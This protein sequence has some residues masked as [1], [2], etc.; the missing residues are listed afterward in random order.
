MVLGGGDDLHAGVGQGFLRA[1]AAELMG[2]DGV[3]AGDDTHLAALA[4]H[5]GQNA[6]QLLAGAVQVLADK[7][8]GLVLHAG[9]GVEEVHRN[10]GVHGL[11]DGGGDGVS[12]AH[13]AN[14]VV[15]HGDAGVNGLGDRLA[16]EGV[17]GLHVYGA[18]VL[19]L[20]QELLYV[21]GALADVHPEGV[22]LGGQDGDADLL[23]G[24]V[25][26]RLVVEGVGDL[27]GGA[28]SLGAGGGVGGRGVGGGIRGGLVLRAARQDADG[29]NQRQQQCESFFHVIIFLS[30]FLTL[31]EAVLYNDTTRF[32]SPFGWSAGG[33]WSL[34]R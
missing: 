23:T 29:H 25:L 11:G 30:Y 10:A 4:H 27:I 15:L 28:G 20:A 24:G 18:V 14:G 2:V 8:S 21:L 33:R 1:S 3:Q 31:P 13:G 16:V 7:G 5:S 26:H 9:V 17:K 22:G 19:I 12:D 6:A 32:T 34:P